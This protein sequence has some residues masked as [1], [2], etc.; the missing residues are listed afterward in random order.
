VAGT[1]KQFLSLSGEIDRAR[2]LIVGVA[3]F[4]VKF[5]L[6]W[7]VANAFDRPWS[8]LNYLVWPDG[9]SLLVHQLP[10]ADRRFALVMLAVALPFI[11]I[12]VT[13]TL[14]R[15]RDARLPL[16]LVVLFF[17]PL[18]NLLLILLLC[19]IS[20]H[21]QQES[22]AAPW[23]TMADGAARLGAP[24]KSGPGA[25]I[26][27]CVASV[28]VVVLLVVVSANVLE[29]YGFGIFVAAPFVQGFLAAILYGLP[30]R[31]TR[32][33]CVKVAVVS[34]GA[35]GLALALFA[36]EG[37]ICI[38]MAAPLAYALC[39]L[40][41]LA[42]Y[43]VQSRPWSN[44]SA[45]ATILGLI[46]ATPLLIAAESMHPKE[47]ALREVRT[48]V[49]VNAPPDRVWNYVVAFPPLPEPTDLLFRTGIAYPQRAEIRGRGVGGVRLC[50]FSSGAFVE[51][52]EVW[53]PPRRLAF[54]VTE[55]PPPMEEL[56]PFDIHPPHL[57]NFLVSHRGQFR[58][59]PTA[60]GRTRLEG[61]TW[62]TNRMWP[63]AYWSIWSDAI[64]HRIHRRV[65]FHVR[66]LAEADHPSEA[67]GKDS[68]E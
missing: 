27:A 20:S 61:T 58:L 52:I 32:G 30:R 34:L 3:L 46:I 28:L 23:S 6:D 15:L 22:L 40:G 57:H 11:W 65:L 54:R 49:I 33:E 60:D 50:V 14:Q 26:F 59:E 41:G 17:I 68:F 51:P 25:F 21:H 4:L 37:L 48:T 62:Y 53:D 39:I 24:E 10:E 66:D 8:P 2:Y 18:V 9:E 16:W 35:T 29:S 47:P 7:S 44:E 67:H 1:L 12:G 45:P 19:L 13:L 5:A 56:S 38:L 36:I 31:R 42:G 64:I 63:A 55:Q 43:A